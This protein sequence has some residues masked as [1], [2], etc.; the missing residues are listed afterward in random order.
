MAWQHVAPVLRFRE[1]GGVAT[2][3]SGFSRL[4]GAVSPLSGGARAATNPGF[5][6]SLCGQ[7]QEGQAG[8]E[9]TPAAWEERTSEGRNPWTLPARNRAGRVSGGARRQ[10][11]EKA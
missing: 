1:S 2:R 11:A 5:S 6:G 10:E 8:R 3:W 4:V 7:R 9:V